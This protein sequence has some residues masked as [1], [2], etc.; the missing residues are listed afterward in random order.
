M[1]VYYELRNVLLVFVAAIRCNNLSIKKY[2]FNIILVFLS[3]LT[4]TKHDQSLCEIPQD[5]CRIWL[6]ALVNFLIVV[7]VWVAQRLYF[8]YISQTH[9]AHQGAWHPKYKHLCTAFQSQPSGF[10]QKQIGFIRLLVYG[11]TLWYP[12][13]YLCWTAVMIAF[14]L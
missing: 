7:L 2:F 10:T 8:D 1:A 5:W 4:L 12:V 3:Y 9:L 14:T 11:W 6:I 13:A